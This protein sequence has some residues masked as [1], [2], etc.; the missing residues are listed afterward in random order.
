LVAGVVVGGAGFAVVAGA[1]VAGAAVVVVAPLAAVVVVDELVVEPESVEVFDVEL[2]PTATAL[3][4]I[5][6][7][8][9]RRGVIPT[10]Y[11]TRQVSGRRDSRRW[12]DP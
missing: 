9:L 8:N 12:S 4:K 3:I 5:V 11:A 6:E 2:Q 7:R 1:V 10:L